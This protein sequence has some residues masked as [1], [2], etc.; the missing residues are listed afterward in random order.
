VHTNHLFSTSLLQHSQVCGL[1]RAYSIHYTL[2]HLLNQPHPNHPATP[3]P[4]IHT[5]PLGSLHML[6]TYNTDIKAIYT[7][8]L[9]CYT[10]YFY[11]AVH[12]RRCRFCT[13]P[14]MMGMMMPETYWD[15]NK[16]IIFCI[17]LVIYSPSQYIEQRKNYG[18][19]RAV[20]RLCVLYPGICLTIEEKARKNLSQGSRRVPVGIMKIHN[21][22]IRIHRHNNKNT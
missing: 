19:V 6:H 22:T 16:Y 12:H 10:L 1:L 4:T 17:Y 7:N 15:T 8:H 21:H 9:L 2:T 3:R 13:I 20:S 5:N 14:L 18:R 11:S